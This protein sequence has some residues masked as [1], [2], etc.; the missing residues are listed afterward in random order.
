MAKKPKNLPPINAAAEYKIRLADPETLKP[1]DKNPRL[2]SQAAIDKVLASVREFGWRQPIVV[3]EDGVIIVG[4]TRRLAAIKGGYKAVPV[5]DALGLTEAQKRAYRLADNRT[6]EESE[7]DMPTLS[8][9]IAGL[10]LDGFDLGPLG[11]DL[12][13]LRG[14]EVTERESDPESVPEAPSKPVTRTGD[15]WQLG[16]HFLLCGDS[17]KPDDVERLTGKTRAALLFTSPPY[18]QQRDYGAAKA[19]VSDWLGLMQGVFAAAPVADGGQVLV[20]LGLVYRDGECVQYWSPWLD[21]MRAQGWRFFGWY[22]WDQGPGLPGDW[23]GRLAPSHEFIFHLNKAAKRARKTV[24]SKM[25]G[26]VSNGGLREKDGSIG[27][28]S[29]GA[30]AIQATKIPDSVFRVMR[31]KGGLSV[32]SHPAIFSVALAEQVIDAYSVAGD[33]IYEPFSGSG[34]TIIAAEKL[35]RSCYALE[36]DPVYVDVAVLRWEHFTGKKAKLAE[37]GETFEQTKK[38]RSKK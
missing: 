5:H 35:G 1:Y 11:F 37:N 6:G 13:E 18:A 16:D 31:H 7:W 24:K 30:S 4:H 28:R 9:E 3:D 26:V 15:V 19:A 34:T 2:I 12:A 25:A 27:G 10:R 29:K 14:L 36:L 38:R 21:F 33:A 22:V 23:N 17:T 20:N 8:A 32:G